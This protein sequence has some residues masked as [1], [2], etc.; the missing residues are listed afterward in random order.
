MVLSMKK[1][2]IIIFIS[3]FLGGNTYS[4]DKKLYEMTQNK[5]NMLKFDKKR[6]LAFNSAL[7]KGNQDEVFCKL[8]ISRTINFNVAH[9]DSVNAE[10]WGCLSGNCDNG[11]GVYRTS[12]GFTYSGNFK[13][14]R[15]NGPGIMK[16]KKKESTGMSTTIYAEFVNGCAQGKGKIITWKGKTMNNI[17]FKN[18]APFQTNE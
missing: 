4:D 7:T 12:I 16:F 9:K 15:L 18:N 6:D 1:L 2:F 10:K 11:D 17:L 3:L 5:L 13:F 8:P 14:G